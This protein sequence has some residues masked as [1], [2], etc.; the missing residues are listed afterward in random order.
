MMNEPNVMLS[1]AGDACIHDLFETQVK[2]TPQAT[3]VVSGNQRVTYTDLNRLA[4]RLAHY[5]R[6]NGVKP[7]DRVGICAERGV[8]LVV[9]LLAV[10]KAGGAYVPLDPE[11]PEERLQYIVKDSA[12]VAVLTQRSTADLLKKIGNGTRVIGLDGDAHG[13]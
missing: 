8:E 6:K 3:A 9:A 2:R 5:L 4:N 13:S 11:Y 7:E 10:L 12:P 1:N